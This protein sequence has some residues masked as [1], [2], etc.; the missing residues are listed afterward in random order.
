MRITS[1]LSTL[2]HTLPRVDGDVTD[3]NIIGR[4]RFA[5]WI[6]TVQTQAPNM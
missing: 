3:D 1:F 4:I 2:A 5:F 6:P